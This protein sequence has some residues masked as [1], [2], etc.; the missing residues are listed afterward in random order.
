MT[1]TVKTVPTT[2]TS[3]SGGMG[4]FDDSGGEEDLFAALSTQKSKCVQY[5]LCFLSNSWINKNSRNEDASYTNS[6]IHVLWS[7]Y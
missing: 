4:L 1:S 7:F 6:Y 5:R 2:T 3:S